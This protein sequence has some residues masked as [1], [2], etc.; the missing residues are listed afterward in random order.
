ME[1][2]EQLEQP[3]EPQSEPLA[4]RSLQ[5]QEALQQEPV[6]PAELRGR[7]AHSPVTMLPEVR[8]PGAQ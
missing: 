6:P 1:A 7:P 4:A 3:D 5:P 2:P 8:P